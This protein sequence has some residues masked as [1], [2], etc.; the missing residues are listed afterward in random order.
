[1]KVSG[2]AYRLHRSY[3]ELSFDI[4]TEF[5]YGNIS[6]GMALVFW[7]IGV[8]FCWGQAKKDNS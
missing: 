4:R 8:N 6:V 3:Q 1:M 5:S 7:T 2:W